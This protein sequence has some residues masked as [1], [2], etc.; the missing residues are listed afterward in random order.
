MD[1][2]GRKLDPPGTRDVQ[3]KAGPGAKLSAERNEAIATINGR[4]ML[5]IY[6]FVIPVYKVKAMWI[7]TG[8]I[9]FSG[10]VVVEERSR[11]YEG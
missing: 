3:L 10:D 2:T 8:N 11:C 1:V 4:P 5:R 9:N 6:G 7:K